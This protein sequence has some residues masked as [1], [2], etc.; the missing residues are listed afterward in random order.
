MNKYWYE[1]KVNIEPILQAETHKRNKEQEDFDGSQPL[2]WGNWM[3]ILLVYDNC[4]A[5]LYFWRGRCK[6]TSS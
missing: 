4:D 3:N 6:E 2:T 5:L 1:H